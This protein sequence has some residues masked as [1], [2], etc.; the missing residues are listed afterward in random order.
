MS[1]KVLREVVRLRDENHLLNE[2]YLN[3]ANDILVYTRQIVGLRNEIRL[4]KIRNKMLEGMLDDRKVKDT[5]D[6]RVVKD[7][8]NAPVRDVKNAIL[9][10][11]ID[12]C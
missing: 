4:L 6:V 10:L 1:D 3:A 7:V 12:E 2:N 8:I 9:E 11:G 5:K